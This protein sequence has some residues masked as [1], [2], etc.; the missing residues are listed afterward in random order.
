MPKPHII[1]VVSGRGGV[2]KTMLAVALAAELARGRKT[3]LFNLDFF[4]RGLTGLFASISEHSRKI[5][6]PSFPLFACVGNDTDWDIAAIGQN[7]LAVCYDDLDKSEAN[8]LEMT[9]I[10][11]LAQTLD[12]YIQMLAEACGAEVI[13]LDCHGGPDNTSFAACLTAQ[14]SLL[15]SEPDR[16]TLHGTLH[17]LRILK[18][19]A[20]S[21]D[22][23]IRLVF[24][25][26][27]PAFST[28]FLFRFYRDFLQSEFGGK[29]LLG[30]YPL[31]AHLTKEFEKT[32]FLTTVYLPR[33]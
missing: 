20:G 19:T 13:V 22:L 12:R 25:K 6:V 8:T 26:V 17:F 21:G 4:N 5:A 11:S 28:P 1:A 31:E 32:P 23:D 14:H 27:I 33:S 29:P 18:R 24:N 3:L 7:L 30:I 15:V 16:I 2:G 9:D 10:A